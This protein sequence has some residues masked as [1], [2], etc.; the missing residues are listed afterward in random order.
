MLAWSDERENAVDITDNNVIVKFASVSDI[1]QVAVVLT[2]LC[3]WGSLEFWQFHHNLHCCKL[4]RCNDLCNSVQ[5]LFVQ[6]APG[7]TQRT[8]AALSWGGQQP[9]AGLSAEFWSCRLSEF[10]PM[11]FF[12]LQP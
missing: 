9:G 12:V 2:L 1:K 6:V 8:M 7:R 3:A 5:L 10:V 11:V 4:C